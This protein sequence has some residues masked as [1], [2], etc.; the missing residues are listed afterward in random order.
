M[1]QFAAA[2]LIMINELAGIAIPN[3]PSILRKGSWHTGPDMFVLALT[4][5]L[6]AGDGRP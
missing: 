4:V 2:A 1:T 6:L 3:Q 5:H